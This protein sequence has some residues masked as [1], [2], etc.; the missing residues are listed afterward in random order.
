MHSLERQLQLHLTIILIAVMA[1]IWAVGLVLPHPENAAMQCVTGFSDTEAM[2]R[3]HR[4]RWLFPLLATVG[5]VLI[6]IVQRVVIRRSFRDFTAIQQNLQALENGTIQKL[7]EH[8]PA[9]IH[10]IIQKFNQVLLQLQERLQRSRNA[11]GNLAHALKGPL[12]FLQQHLAGAEDEL[13]RL[14]LERLHKLIERE[15]KRARMAGGG[16]A[17][18]HFNP[19]QDL[20]TLVELLSRVHA[21]PATALKLDIAEDITHFADR[22][23]M[24]ELLGNLLDNACK[25]AQSQVYCQIHKVDGKIQL[26]VEDDGAGCSAAELAQMG[27]RGVRLDEAVSGYGL[28]LAICKDIVKLYGGSIQFSRSTKLGGLQVSVLL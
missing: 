6:L 19:W 25:W 28:G 15:L 8:V 16:N 14:Q 3:P 2:Q 12:N 23:D 13:A 21:L 10:P 26:I 20:P 17:I 22:E 27:E 7:S 5:I 18:Q 1:L 4:F 11:V 9:E 24:L